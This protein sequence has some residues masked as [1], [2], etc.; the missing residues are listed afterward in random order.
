MTVVALE[1]RP[2]RAN[3]VTMEMPVGRQPPRPRPARK[4]STPNQRTLGAKAAAKVRTE[5]TITAPISI[6]RRPRRSVSQPIPSAPTIMPNRPA[7]ATAVPSPVVMSKPLSSNRA[8]ITAPRTT[9]SNPSSRT[10][11]QH[12]GATQRG[13]LRMRPLAGV[14]PAVGEEAVELTGKLFR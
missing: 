13:D 7:V 4:R 1:P 8:G 9:A 5:N 3:S 10:A 6:L 11:I 12:S 2:L 14:V